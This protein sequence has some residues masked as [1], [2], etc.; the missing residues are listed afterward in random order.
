MLVSQAF[1]KIFSRSTPLLDGKATI[2]EAS[3]ILA[4]LQVSAVLAL[5]DKAT[6]EDMRYKALTGFYVLSK[7]LTNKED[8]S[9][10]LAT[11]CAELAR[12]I[13]IVKENES[14]SHVIGV[15]DESRIG[16]VLV[17]GNNNTSNVLT[18]LELRDFVR[19][20]RDGKNLPPTNLKLGDLA[21]SP[22]ISLKC[23]TTLEDLLNTM[24]RYRVRKIFLPE[25]KSVIS[26]RDVLSYMTS[27]GGIEQVN[28]SLDSILKTPAKDLPSTRP[29]FVDSRMSIG[30]AASLMNPDT[31][32]CLICDR[33]LV[34]FWDIVV[35][36]ERSKKSIE[37]MLQ[38]LAIAEGTSSSA[39][40]SSYARGRVPA[41]AVEKDLSPSE[42]KQLSLLGKKMR[43]RGFLTFDEV[44]YFARQKVVDPLYFKRPARLFQVMGVSSAGHK[45]AIKFSS[46]DLFGLRKLDESYY[47][48]DWE[49]FSK[50]ISQRLE[51][52]FRA[53]NPSPSK[54]MKKAF[55]RFMHNFGL[56]W[57]D[58]YHLIRERER[59]VARA[60]H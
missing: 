26:D 34:T 15:I 44:P 4:A 41:H 49:R 1:P 60:T 29:P 42:K 55:T 14:L 45:G 28:K 7:I 16:V 6:G 53:T 19:L 50:F 31:G 32:D 58:C 20:Y 38:E 48:F 52:M 36:L 5:D 13:K 21:S 11:H 57:T 10:Y 22:V 3:R 25:T 51:V 54:H 47:V 30:E 43:E 24:L 17:S 56:H 27:P 23:E 12:P 40:L 8:F 35:K 33:G 18:T 59:L 46:V 39:G 9:K 2:L 37:T